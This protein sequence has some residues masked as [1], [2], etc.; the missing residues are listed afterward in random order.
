MNATSVSTESGIM[1]TC[2]IIR[3]N[4]VRKVFVFNI[5][6]QCVPYSPYTCILVK[7]FT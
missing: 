7:V 6:I 5:F 3:I 4:F 1:C 2:T